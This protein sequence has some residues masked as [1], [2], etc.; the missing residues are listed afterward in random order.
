MKL[1]GHELNNRLGVYFIAVITKVFSTFAWG[2][3]SFN[4][5][6][7]KSQIIS[8]P[9]VE[10]ADPNHEYTVD[11]IDWQ[12]M[13]DRIKELEEDRIKEL[14]AY[15]KAANLDDYELTEED[16]KVLSLSLSLSLIIVLPT[17]Y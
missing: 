11:D 9:V 3:N 10:H 16:K 14:D 15:L 12:Y 5:K 2:Q 7:I 1:K 8:L 4:E 6:I 13:E 17:Y